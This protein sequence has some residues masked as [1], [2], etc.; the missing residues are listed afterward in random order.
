[1]LVWSFGVLLFELLGGLRPSQSGNFVLPTNI[2]SERKVLFDIFHKCTVLEADKRP[3]AID[4]I[5]DFEDI[6][7]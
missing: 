4:L 2:P 5:N 7:C 6:S 3:S 1:M